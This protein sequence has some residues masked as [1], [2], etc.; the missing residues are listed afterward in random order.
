MDLELLLNYAV[1]VGA[2]DILLKTNC[3][4]KYRI[5]GEL[6]SGNFNEIVTADMMVKWVKT[7]LPTHLTKKFES[8]GEADFS[9]TN[10]NHIRFRV[11]LFRQRQSFSAVLRVI[12]SAVQSLDELLIPSQ[13]A[14]LTEYKRGLVLITGATGSGKSTTLASLINKINNDSYSHIVTVEDPIEFWFEDVNSTINQREIGVDTLSFANAL[15]AALRQNPDVILVGELRDKETIETALMAAETGHLVFS[16]LHT[17]NASETITRLLSY[18]SPEQEKSIRLVLSQ[19]LRGVISQRL[20]PC[21]DG[22]GMIAAAEIM[23]VNSTIQ[24]LI[25]NAKSFEGIQ[26]AIKNGSV[27]HGMQTFDQS[28]M[29]LYQQGLISQEVLISNAS[30]R[31]DIRLALSGIAS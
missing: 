3:S 6:I 24:D 16:T 20:V 14:S 1:K 2:S 31:D 29:Y 25:L 19:T 17:S 11:N 27:G 9:F 5:G 7:L 13:V 4:P 23:F 12:N 22:S 21:I 30:N 28:L 8:L 18:F 15:R 10:R 26:D